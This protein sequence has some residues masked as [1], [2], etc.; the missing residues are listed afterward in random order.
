MLRYQ[1]FVVFHMLQL[2]TQQ[3]KFPI[4]TKKLGVALVISFYLLTEMLFSA[5]VCASIA[6]PGRAAAL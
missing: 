4:S 6:Q 1:S 3:L 2:R 5:E